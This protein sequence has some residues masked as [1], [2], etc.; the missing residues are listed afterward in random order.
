MQTI[1]IE[2]NH[3]GQR[4]DKFLHKFLPEAPGSFF[5]KMLRKKNITLNGRKAEG[6]EL[7]QVGDKVTLYLSEETIDK[8]SGRS[9]CASACPVSQFQK[10][11]TVL[12]GIRVLYED[13]FVLALDKPAGV[14]T[15]KAAPGDLSLNE[16]LIGY[17][18]HTGAITSE[19]LRAFHPSVC[20]RLDR[21]TSGLVLCGKSLAGSQALSR[22][23]RER[24][25]R[26]YYRTICCGILDRPSVIEGY[27]T[28]DHRSNQVVVTPTPGAGKEKGSQI[29]T[30]YLP[31]SASTEN[32]CRKLTYLEVE[33]ITGKTHQIR[34]H[35]SSIG[36]PLIG[37][38]KYGCPDVNRYFLSAY[39]LRA[40]LLHAYRLEFPV[41]DGALSGLSGRAITA[42][43]PEVF[44]E[45]LRKEA[46]E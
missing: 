4:F 23:I 10:A 37:D 8:F 28:K 17:L 41:L 18:L 44:T 22:V 34:A 46:V 36:H 30:G 31:L 7:L 26:K 42:R 9:D 38:A 39:S 13:E 20:N 43:L 15:Q 21:N 5:Y 25:V 3:A 45:I 32:A 6:R 14:L 40:Q 35:L 11:F 27:L 16:W 1:L 19:G 12:K 24:G 2:P 29:Q 33:L